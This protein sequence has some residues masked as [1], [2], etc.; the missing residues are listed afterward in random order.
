[1]ARRRTRRRAPPS[2]LRYEHEH[3]TVSFR[4]PRVLYDNLKEILAINEQSFADFVKEALGAKTLNV[5]GAH[6]NGYRAA[7]KASLLIVWP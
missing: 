5:E 4:V 3:P 1:M 2:R 7:K 6:T